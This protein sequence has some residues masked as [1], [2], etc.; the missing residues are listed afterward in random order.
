MEKNLVNLPYGRGTLTYEINGNPARYQLI[1]P[2]C[3]LSQIRYSNKAVRKALASPIG[4]ENPWAGVGE[5]STVAITVNDKTRPVPNTTL[6]PPLLGVLQTKGVKKENITIYIASGTHIPMDK[7]EFPLVLGDEIPQQFSVI[8]HNC[9]DENKL[10]EIGVTFRKTP[11]F[12]NR[13]FYKCDI[14]IVV[15]DIEP[16][17]FAGYSGGVKSAA[18]G[19]AGRKTIN[20]N[21]KLLL[22]ENSVIGCFQQNPLRQDIEEIG[23]LMKIDLALN[24]VLNQEKEILAV[25]F[26]KPDAVMKAGI[27]VVDQISRIPISH[28]YD[29]VIASA[30]GYPKDINLYQAQK[31]MT[32]ASLFC[33]PG[34]VI[35][36]IAE[37]EEGVGSNGYLEFM[38]GIRNI[39]EVIEKFTRSEFKVGPH[40]AFQIAK[41]LQ[42]HQVFLFSSIPVR[43]VESLLLK[44]LTSLQEVQNLV[45]RHPGAEIALLPYATA[46]IAAYKKE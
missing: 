37:C 13:G 32:H 10:C 2:N 9:D 24:A 30:G 45:D 12:V 21:H 42:K 22:D 28:A 5:E 31:A 29:I 41:I 16:H 14:K 39:H 20:T 1:Q 23:S 6:L 17:H 4:V 25:F 46:C 7:G 3:E 36:L 40:K 26:G 44:P 35:V 15:G 38:R 19:L 27:Q 34:G 18:I 33:K 8:P 43:Q 11:V